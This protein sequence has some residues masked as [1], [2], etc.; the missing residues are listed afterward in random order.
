MIIFI[1]SYLN[2]ERKFFAIRT[3]ASPMDSSE[4]TQSNN[5]A[6]NVFLIAY[7]PL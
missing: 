2:E 1:S 7:S 3:F 4:T 5:I 6:K